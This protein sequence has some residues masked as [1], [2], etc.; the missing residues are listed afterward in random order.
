MIDDL[1]D[2]FDPSSSIQ[3]RRLL[4][5]ICKMRLDSDD[6]RDS[7]SE[8]SEDDSRGVEI[9][10]SEAGDDQEKSE[11]KKSETESLLTIN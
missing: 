4:Y 3:D 2:G 10:G 8:C 7:S 11:N 6:F 1:I 9:L 5:E